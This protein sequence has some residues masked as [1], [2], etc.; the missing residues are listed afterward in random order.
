MGYRWQTAAFTELNNRELYAALRL[1]QQVFVVEQSSLYVDLD[2][3]DQ[4]A[5]HMLVWEGESLLAYQ[6]CL[7]PGLQEVES[8]L[9]RIVV[10]PAARGTHLGRELVRRGI[11]HNLR[12]WPNANIRIHAQAR[13]ERYY[14]D[15]GFLPEGEVYDLDSIPHLDMLYFCVNR[16]RR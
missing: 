5:V 2:D 16:N 9:G 11:N 7:P 8:T 6:R 15:L 4:E 12:R 13:L 14:R 10:T 3:F 1:R